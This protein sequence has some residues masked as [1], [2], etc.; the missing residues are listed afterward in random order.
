M[1]ETFQELF[2]ATGRNLIITGTCIQNL[3]C[4]FFNHVMYSDMEIIKALEITTCI[5]LLLKPIKYNSKFYVDG[6]ISDNYIFRDCDIIVGNNIDLN[7][8]FLFDQR[9][10]P[11]D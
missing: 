11:I 7:R 5:P 10:D 2:E 9:F 6:A 8:N 3:E 1:V 4:E